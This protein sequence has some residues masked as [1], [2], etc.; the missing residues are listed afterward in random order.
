LG[1]H[2][3]NETASPDVIPAKAGIHGFKLRDDLTTL[4]DE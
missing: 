1:D 2:G 3:D 4:E